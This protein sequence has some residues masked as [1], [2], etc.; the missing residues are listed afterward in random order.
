[1]PQIVHMTI[2][3]PGNPTRLRLLGVWLLVLSPCAALGDPVCVVSG[4]GGVAVY[5][6][7]PPQGTC[8]RV[9]IGDTGGSSS[10]ATRRETR[11]RK[12]I[13]RSVALHARRFGVPQKLVRA[14]IQA[15]SGGNPVAVSPKGAQGIMQLMPATARRFDVSDPLDPDQNIEGG[16]RYLSYLLDLYG[17]NTPLALAAY[18]AGEEAV[19]RHR[20][21]P[22]FEETRGYVR[23]VLSIAGS[24]GG[25]GAGR[26]GSPAAP[27]VRLV[28]MPGGTPLLEN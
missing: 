27:P 7:S 8:D 20:G 10:R 12:T 6:N 3:W 5:T 25:R 14:V 4:T 16:V 11:E 26:I 19:R 13:D 22:P 23:K 18:N 2:S 9:M 1:M 17:G 28:Q 21:I 15:E 24:A